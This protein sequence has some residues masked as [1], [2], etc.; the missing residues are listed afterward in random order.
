MKE[1]REVYKALGTRWYDRLEEGMGS[2][3]KP[4]LPENPDE[5]IKMCSLTPPLAR[6]ISKLDSSDER[7]TRAVIQGSFFLS[8]LAVLA[9]IQR[10]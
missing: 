3:P 10:G 8:K 1:L 7:Y 2:D 4:K 6:N 5:E 9:P